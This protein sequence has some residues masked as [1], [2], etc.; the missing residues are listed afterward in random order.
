MKKSKK[1][2]G[3]GLVAI[4]LQLSGEN[5]TGN[6]DINANVVGFFSLIIVHCSEFKIGLFGSANGYLN[7]RLI[8]L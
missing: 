3:V 8:R 4:P 6:S 1:K 5:R 7:G 2:N